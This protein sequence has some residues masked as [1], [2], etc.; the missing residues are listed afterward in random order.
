MHFFQWFLFRD[1]GVNCKWIFLDQVENANDELI[2][3]EIYLEESEEE[4]EVTENCHHN[5]EPTTSL[6]NV[7]LPQPKTKGYSITAIL[8]T[9]NIFKLP[10]T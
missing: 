4:C 8:S 6:E 1:P 5:S 2:V 7:E 3:E 9:L 10:Q